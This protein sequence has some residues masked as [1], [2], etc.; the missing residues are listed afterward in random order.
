MAWSRTCRSSKGQSI[1]P[2]QKLL[3]FQEIS[4]PIIEVETDEANLKSLRMGQ[5]AVISSEAYPGQTFEAT[6]YDLG[7]KVDADRGTIKVK[8]R[9]HKAVGWLRPDLTV[10]VNIITSARARRIVL[11]ADTITR[12]DGRS[13]VYAVRDGEAVP[14]V[15]VP[16]AVGPN[17]VAVT[18][19]LSD[20]TLVARNASGVQAGGE[21]VAVTR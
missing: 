2:G 7:S 5:S 1:S 16:G 15:V 18:G 17:G 19:D 21:V 3:V 11:P 9:P 20:G 12:H 8:L 13:V 14:V 10:D 4:R 6:H